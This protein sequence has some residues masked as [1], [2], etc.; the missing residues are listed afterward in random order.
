MERSTAG[1]DSIGLRWFAGYCVHDAVE[2]AKNLTPNIGQSQSHENM[3]KYAPPERTSKPMRH[4]VKVI[5]KP[6]TFS[7]LCMNA[8]QILCFYGVRAT[9]CRMLLLKLSCHP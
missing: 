4:A 9:L 3:N 6:E 1:Q 7:F 5:K 2:R 8:E